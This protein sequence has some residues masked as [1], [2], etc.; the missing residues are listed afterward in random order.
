MNKSSKGPQDKQFK[1]NQIKQ[2]M[3]GNYKSM[4]LLKFY[5]TRYAT[6]YKNKYIYIN[7]ALSRK[8]KKKKKKKKK[9]LLN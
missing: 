9:K 2:R 1:Y 5:L 3:L 7:V 6:L 8:L 4:F